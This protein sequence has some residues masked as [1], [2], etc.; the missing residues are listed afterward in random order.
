MRIG[1]LTEGGYPYVSGDAGL[2]CDRLVRGL[3]HHEF[4]VYAF[5]RSEAQEDGGWVPLPPQVGR[6]RTAPLWTAEDDGVVYGRR[7]RRRFAEH[8]G[9]LAAVLCTSDPGSGSDPADPDADPGTGGTTR[10]PAEADRFTGALYGLAELARDEGGLVAALRSETAV[11]ALERACHAPRVLPA[12][13]EARV[14][15]LLAVAAHLHEALRPLSLDWYE[16]DGLGAVD[17][18]H[19]ASGGTAALPGL[20]AGHFFDVPLLVTEY[21]VRLRTHYLT[22]PD[23]SPAVRSLLAAFH[24]R[25]AAET[26]RRA[27]FITPGNTHARRW[28]ERCG[29]DRAKVRTVHPGMDAAPF[30]E[31]GESPERAD[32]HTLVWTGRVEPAKDLVSLLHAFAGIRAAEPGA[33]LRIIGGPAGPEGAAYLEHCRELA[34]R[35][36]PDGTGA[37]HADGA[38]PVSFEEIGGPGLTGPADAYAAAAV[39]VLS[40]V[41]EGFPT[42]LVEAMLAGRATVSTDVGAVVEVVGGTGLVVPPRDPEAFAEACVSLLRDPE[43]RARLGAAARARALELFTVEQ[44]IAAFHDLYLEIVARTPA[45]RVRLNGTGD[46]L[47]FAAPVEAHVPGHWTDPA[48]RRPPRTAPTWATDT[49]AR[50]PSPA[51]AATHPVPGASPVP[52]T[53]AAR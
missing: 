38:G 11:R 40:S 39:T 31:V 5:S 23:S 17:L 27:A 49:P 25:L 20:L 26:Y 34:A 4:D 37:P 22:R 8:Y 14:S 42:G 13:R 3:G 24:G 29:A 32:P 44:N 30:A 43:R 12:A 47:P 28:Q 51:R 18:C 2:W 15:D 36:F 1:L 33:R 48:S 16:E 52:A 45:R 7:A 6:V 19:A 50:A 10:A 46:P 41:V 53:E 21:G 35:F 9:E